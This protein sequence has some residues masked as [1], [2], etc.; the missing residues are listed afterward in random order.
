MMRGVYFEKH[1]KVKEVLRLGDIP[2]PLET[3]LAPGELLIQ[4]F[5][6]ALNPADYKSTEGEQKLLLNFHWPRQYGFDFS[7]IVIA[8]N[9]HDTFQPNYT[10]TKSKLD[11]VAVA[12]AGKF[13]P[14]DKVF[15]MI[16]TL[17]MKHRGTIAEY[18]IVEADMCAKCPP[19]LSHIE[20]AAVPLVA[21]T[22]ELMFSS[23]K[24]KESDNAG[25]ETIRKILILGGSG[26]V[27]S[28]AIQMAKHKYQPCH[29]TTTASLRKRD[30][31][32]QLGSDEVVDYS[33]EAFEKFVEENKD[34][35]DIILDCVGDAAKCVPLLKVD[36]GMASI[37]AGHT[38]STLVNWITQNK[39]AQDGQV[40][41]KLVPAFLH[42]K[43]G[44]V[45]GLFTGG[46][47]LE[48]A[49]KAKNA[50]FSSVIAT[51][52]GE[53]LEKVAQLLHEGHLKPV[54]DHVFKF[55]DALDAI[56]YHRAGRLEKVGKVVVEIVSEESSTIP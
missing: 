25:G 29:V 46:W 15:G 16:G 53:K 23:C 33:K 44:C 35:F 42:S 24:L 22:A 10:G 19:N 13:S 6:G 12:A 47:S 54:V 52:N 32:L 49:C 21:L 14:G 41:T 8:I 50:H 38:Q 26:G 55:S 37:Q 31:L 2:K 4:V 9:G 5:A 1:G 11:K 3:E 34:S 36:G 17:P 56:F 51:G 43:M 28:I 18:L 39:L 20:C 27:G 40:V 7:G 30:L 48:K 45:V